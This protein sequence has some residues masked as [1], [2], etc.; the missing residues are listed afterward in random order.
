MRIKY[1]WEMRNW[2]LLTINIKTDFLGY[3]QVKFYLLITMGFIWH[4]EQNES[5]CG[6]AIMVIRSKVNCSIFS[7]IA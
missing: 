6:G 4:Y 3:Q 5:V 2:N 1:N 7:T